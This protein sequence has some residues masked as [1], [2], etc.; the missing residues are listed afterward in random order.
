MKAEGSD[1]DA[2]RVSSFA[3]APQDTGLMVVFAVLCGS[4]LVSV[5]GAESGIVS[6]KVLTHLPLD[7]V[8]SSSISG[9]T[10]VV[11]SSMLSQV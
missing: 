1:G 4:P 9:V 6:R 3:S 8:G 7:R 2:G 10:G 11:R 5:T